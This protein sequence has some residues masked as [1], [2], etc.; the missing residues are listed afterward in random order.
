MQINLCS[1][2]LYYILYLCTYKTSTLPSKRR[3]GENIVK[4]RPA[5]TRPVIRRFGYSEV[6]R[7][8]RFVFREGEYYYVEI[9][10]NITTL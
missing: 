9:I 2:C 5:I 8:S 7:A 6:S 10:A 1:L 4:S 3:K